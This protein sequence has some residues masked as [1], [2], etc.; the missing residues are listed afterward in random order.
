MVDVMDAHQAAQT[1]QRDQIVST[2][3]EVPRDYTPSIKSIKVAGINSTEGCVK[4]GPDTPKP[5]WTD[6]R[7]TADLKLKKFKSNGKSRT[8]PGTIGDCPTCQNTEAE[9]EVE[10]KPAPVTNGNRT[11]QPKPVEEVTNMTTKTNALGL[12]TTQTGQSKGGRAMAKLENRDD[13][14]LVIVYAPEGQQVEAIT[15]LLQAV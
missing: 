12:E 8:H 3:I 10:V 14:I 5:H 6:P 15:R 1:W 7:F 11:H 2:F 9:V 13:H 4:R